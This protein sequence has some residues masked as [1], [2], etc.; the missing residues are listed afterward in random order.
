MGVRRGRLRGSE[1]KQFGARDKAETIEALGVRE[2]Q[3]AIIGNSVVVS[4][5]DGDAVVTIDGEA[6]TRREVLLQTDGVNRWQISADTGAESG[7]NAGS[8]FIIN[9]YADD[10]TYLSSPIYVI[11][12]TGEVR[13][14]GLA[15]L[16]VTTVAALPAGALGNIAMV[17]DANATT[18]HS[19]VAGGGSNVVPVF[20]DGTNW[21]IG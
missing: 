2:R 4:S 6:G 1:F 15:K 20:H 3:D 13:F 19:V 9:A 14:G 21:R 12:A 18:F 17:T 16:L 8:N 7:S 5:D 10:G 11:R